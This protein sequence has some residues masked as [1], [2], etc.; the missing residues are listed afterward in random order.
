MSHQ[1]PQFESIFRTLQTHGVNF[2]LIGGVCASL[3]GSSMNTRDVD[4]VPQRTDQ[5]LERLA[6]AL[7]E[8]RAYYRQHPPFKILPDSRRLDTFGHHLLMS[9]FGPI[10]ILGA[11][12]GR[13][14]YDALMPGTIEVEIDDIRIRMLDLPTLITI[15]RET[16]R[17]KDRLAVT[18]LE[19]IL[20]LRSS[21]SGIP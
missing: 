19:E 10:D 16:G 6:G 13:R 11:I 9:D 12:V 15:K 1:A 3:H 17:P 2:I 20:E 18:V 8:M 14:D 7:A 4:I 21:D 5:N